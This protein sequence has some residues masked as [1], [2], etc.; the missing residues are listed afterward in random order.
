MRELAD[1]SIAKA[2]TALSEALSQQMLTGVYQSTRR[3]L[4]V[5]Y[6]T[7]IACADSSGI[8]ALSEKIADNYRSPFLWYRKAMTKA[9]FSELIR[10]VHPEFF[11]RKSSEASAARELAFTRPILRIDPLL[12]L[13]PRKC[14]SRDALAEKVGVEPKDAGSWRAFLERL[15]DEAAENGNTGIKQLQAYR[16]SLDFAPRTDGEVDWSG[17]WD[18][19][20]QRVWEDWIVHECCKQAHERGW[21]H[22]VH[23]G[24]HNLKESSPLPLAHLGR[25]Y[26]RM[27]IVQI[28]CWPFLEE[29]GWLAKNVPNF[30]VDT[31]WLPILNPFYF[32]HAL[33]MW[34]NYIPLHKIM[35]SHDATSVEMAVG[36]AA[37]T[38]EIM[39]DVMAEQ[40]K[41]G[42][43][44]FRELLQI[45]AGFL[46]DNAV[47]IY[48]AGEKV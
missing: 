5:L 37:V 48:G 19:G 44:S 45:A 16:R 11:Y 8:Q 1:R 27:K 7:D 32:R 34:I 47:E 17:Q 46:H 29:A 20:Q 18:E 14:P 13:G 40:E 4:E 2:F 30:F 23:V 43:A 31:C 25:R 26:P 9:H 6:G 42:A 38:R 24:T 41:A 21:P 35:C 3:G 12:S 39:G 10:P 36:S 33:Q 22:Q 28:H 15:F